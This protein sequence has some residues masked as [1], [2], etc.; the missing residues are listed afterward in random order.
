M[1]RKVNENEVVGNV[2]IVID[3]V[4]V[5]IINILSTETVNEASIWDYFKDIV[6]S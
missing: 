1:L 3:G 4:V 5:D 6:N 2:E